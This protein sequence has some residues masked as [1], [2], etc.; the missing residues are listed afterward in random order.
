MKASLAGMGW[1]LN[2]VQL[3]GEYLEAGRLVEVVPGTPL[4]IPLYWQ[5]NRLAAERLGTLTAHVVET[6][7]AALLS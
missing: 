6:A 1:G 7:R 2:P 4:D 5:V 3:V